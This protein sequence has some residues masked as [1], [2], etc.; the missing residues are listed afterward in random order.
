MAEPSPSSATARRTRR[1]RRTRN[2][3]LA[4]AITQRVGNH[5]WIVA[6]CGSIIAVAVAAVPLI[7]IFASRAEVSY[8]ARE[9]SENLIASIACDIE[10][11]AQFHDLYLQRMVSGAQDVRVWNL[12]DDLRSRI[13]FGPATEGAFV[14]GADGRVLEGARR[15]DKGADL[16]DRPYFAVHRRDRQVGLYVSQPFRP[17]DNELSI[18]LTRRID[19]PDGIFEGVGVVILPVERLRQLFSY[20]NV[21]ASGRLL[22]VR[23]DGT[24]LAGKPLSEDEIGTSIAHLPAF[25]TI[26][27]QRSGSVIGADEH[28]VQHIYSFSRIQGTPLIAIVAPTLDSVLANWRWQSIVTEVI[29]LAFAV[30]LVLGTWALAFAMRDKIRAQR[31]LAMLAATDPLTGLSNRRVLEMRLAATWELARRHGTPLS[32]LFVDIDHFKMFNDSHGYAAGDRA[33]A[34]VAHCIGAAARRTIDIVARY[35][36]EEFAAV[37]PETP[38]ADAL[39][40]AETIRERVEALGLPNEGSAQGMVTVSIGCATAWSTR[41]GEPAQ[42]LQLADAQLYVAKS[43]GRNQV[44]AVVIDDVAAALQD[45]TSKAGVKQTAHVPG[46]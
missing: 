7:S 3:R 43:A 2:G 22:I 31:D 1:T 15:A 14:V 23:N 21:D 40:I 30:L 42:L 28:G 6:L 18:A 16:G 29:A 44:K 8:R 11:N 4:T 25:A 38:G 34:A 46:P 35:G 26:A 13:L 41:G 17:P 27:A 12:P 20:I 39:T 9:A 24:V 32:I 37:L 5:P 10:Q 36:G 33:L 19:G 45:L